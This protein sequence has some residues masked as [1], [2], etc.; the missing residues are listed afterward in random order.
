[1]LRGKN[2]KNQYLCGKCNCFILEGLQKLFIFTNFLEQVRAMKNLKPIK[3]T[4]KRSIK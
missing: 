3:V 2:N 4:Q 1:M